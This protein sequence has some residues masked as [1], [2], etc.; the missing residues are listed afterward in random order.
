MPGVQRL[1]VSQE[2]ADLRLDRWFRR[3]IPG[4]GHGRLEKLLR[5]GEIRLDGARAKASDRVSAG[6][7]VRIPPLP[8]ADLDAKAPSRP[9][10]AAPTPAEAAELETRILHMDEAVIAFNKPP[11]LPV[12]GG[13]GHQRHLDG[14]LDALRF[15]ARERPRL[16]HRL[17]KDTSG[18]MLLAR[19][20]AAA[21]A[22]TRAFRARETR[23]IYWA[24]L[25]G[26]PKP[27]RG[28]VRLALVKAPGHGPGG[29]GEKMQCVPAEAA[30]RVEGAKGAVT[31]YVVLEALGDR[32]S[33]AA[34]R[35]ITGRT[36]QL[37]AHM[38]AI[39][40]PIVGDGK[41]A[42]S[43]PVDVA[44]SPYLGGEISKK[45][46]LHSRRL[47][48]PHPNGDTMLSVE[49]PLPPHMERSWRA[50]G[51]AEGAAAAPEDPFNP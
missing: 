38:A 29:A 43:D 33:W 5:K 11:G 48:V 27:R 35:P 32:A 6:Q 23:K 14:M 12:Q 16:T 30:S 24:A 18:V 36:H 39:G 46:H 21:A 1:T 42:A 7:V 4:L 2:E 28:V 20:R 10:A 45:L 15:G 49:A 26:A 17:D 9:K 13:S 8:D 31:E 51:W 41:Y 50:L 47:V 22:L 40:C 3:R 34:L 44:R 19:S 37:R 25:S